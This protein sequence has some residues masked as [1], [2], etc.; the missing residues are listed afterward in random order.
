MKLSVLDLAPVIAPA[1]PA[2]ALEQAAVLAQTAERLGYARYWV[3]EHHDMPGL[4]CTAPEVL[5][6]HIGARTQRIRLGSGALLLPHYKPMKVAES[7]HM[8]ATLYPGRIDLGIGRAPGGS[9]HAAIAL[10]GNFLGNVS[11]MPET[12]QALM[13]F[14][15][16]RYTYEDQPVT[17][18]PLPA[19]PPQVWLLGT[20]TKSAAFAAQHGAGYVFGHFMSD[21]DGAETI[22]AYRE[23]FQPAAHMAE[24]KAMLAIAAICAETEEEAKRLAAESQSWFR[25]P[26]EQNMPQGSGRLLTGTPDSLRVQLESLGRICHADEYLIVSP[27]PDYEKRLR[28]YELLAALK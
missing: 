21:A 4:A 3:A 13:D 9:A 18:R 27:V 24:P 22:A 12:L 16:Q 23:Q 1:D 17:A 19:E 14:L 5:L 8:L 2:A 6:A 15:H 20:N 25:L 10:S 11:R 28:S 26:S 7:F